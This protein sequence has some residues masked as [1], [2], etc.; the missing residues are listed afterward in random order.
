MRI[1]RWL[2]GRGP[3]HSGL[4]IGNDAS[5]KTTMLYKLKLGEI[6]TTIPTI[7]FNV[8]TL[9]YPDGG[10]ITLWDV[11]GCDKIR[12]LIRH[13]MQPDRFLIFIQSCGDLDPDRIEFSLEYL[14][15]GLAMMAEQGCRHMF[16]L[17]NKQ[18]LLPPDERDSIVKGI[19]VQIEKEIAPYLGNHDI[20]I[21][22][23][24]GLC[25]TSGEQ[26]YPA[27]EEIRQTI[28]QIKKP[29]QPD[30][31][32]QVAEL[33]KGPSDTEL[34]ER[35]KKAN[36][37]AVDAESFWA[38]FMDGS[39][40][41]WDHYTHLRAGFFVLHDCFARGFGLLECADEFMA[42][43]N[44]LRQGNPER[45]RNTAHKTMTIFWLHQ[46]Q[47][48]A[49][50]Y[51]VNNGRDKFPDRGEYAAIALSAPWL[52]N[53]GLWRSYYS[54]DMLF[55]P[56]ARENWHLPDLQ[57]LPTPAQAKV[58]E[59]Q[60]DTQRPGNDVDRVPRF[61]FSVVQ[62]TLTSK[63]RRGGVVKQALEALQSST[64][65]L[66]ASDP[67]VSPYSETQA[68]FWVQ[69]VHAYLRSLE[70]EPS[71][72]SKGTQFEGSV[73]TLTFEAFKALFDITGDEW[74]QYYSPSVWQG[75]PARMS[76][77]NPDKKALPNVFGMPS[78]AKIDLARS[79]MVNA[80]S[81]RF[82]KPSGLPPRED[83]DFWA[84][85]LI[86]EARLI[87]EEE[88]IVANHASL[89]RFLYQRL[90]RAS[91]EKSSTVAA[92]TAL[93]LSSS[94]GSTQSMFWV[95]QVQLCLASGKVASKFE[96]FVTANAHLAYEDLPLVYYSPQLW[97][98]AEVKEVYV[99][100]DRHSLSSIV[101]SGK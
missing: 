90:S 5:G 13:Y 70:T 21:L 6:V 14:R 52:M 65:R 48:A 89:L 51:Q 71:K 3:E 9:E 84:A 30:T 80:V 27:M 37:N 53:S 64:I 69:I 32:A 56:E 7:G 38:S 88:V 76:F 97:Q 66:R 86:D 25:A 78:K 100:P 81:R 83:L 42:H 31:K 93:E 39:L 96:E 17:F 22:D 8:E 55:T 11:G 94:M 1:A 18:D 46:I 49:V 40:N 43:L 57:P 28:Q 67:S 34:I 77:V 4:I 79:Q 95:Q 82:T 24:P 72:A 29:A 41:S 74:R 20:R 73:T 101:S 63:L 68:Y 47:I 16:I 45:F 2:L 10:K 44:R 99:P 92:R 33:E 59:E 61:A 98:S 12:P 54:K 50:N 15:M 85:V 75:I 58:E 87:P 23:Y 62:K 26:L 36:A 35:V 91:E 60:R 19:R